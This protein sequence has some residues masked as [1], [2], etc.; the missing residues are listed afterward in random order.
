MILPGL[1]IAAGRI[2]VRIIVRQ[3]QLPPAAA[4]G[5]QPVQPVEVQGLVRDL[6]PGCADSSGQM[7]RPSILCSGSLGADQAGDRGQQVDGHRRFAAD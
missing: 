3:V 4:H 1:R 7:S 6:A 2:G 5:L